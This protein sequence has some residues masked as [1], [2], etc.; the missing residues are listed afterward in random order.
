[1]SKAAQADIGKAEAKTAVG[2]TTAEVIKAYEDGKARRYALLFAV[3]GGAFAIAKALAGTQKEPGPVVG[4]LKLWHLAVGMG[5]YTTAMVVDIDAFGLT[6]RGIKDDLFGYVGV[7][8]LVLLGALLVAGWALAGIPT[9]SDR[10]PVWSCEYILQ[11]VG[12]AVAAHVGFV[13]GCHHR[14][15]RRLREWW[16]ALLAWN[17]PVQPGG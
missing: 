12:V 7:W 1:M 6:M 4:A 15:D 8:V 9:G 2:M 5:L 11:T 17:R 14:F 13:L 3:N 10:K 16:R